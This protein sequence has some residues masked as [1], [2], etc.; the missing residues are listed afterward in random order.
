MKFKKPELKSAKKITTESLN[1]WNKRMALLHAV[2]GIAVLILSKAVAWPITTSYLTLDTLA[3]KGAGK[4]VLAS[5][6]RTLFNVNLGYFV[7][8]FFF[9]SAI[10]HAII[11]TKYRK[12]YEAD[13][14]KGVN[15]ARW[16]EYGVSA[17]TMMV[18]IALLSGINDL[19]SLIMIFVLDLI[20]NLMGLVMETHNQGAKKV[21]WLTYW[22]G[23]LAG[24]VPWIVFG[25]YV[26]GA[27]VNGSGIPT[28]VYFIYGS[29][30]IFF[31]SFAINMYLQYTKKGKWANYLYGERA[32]MILSLVAKTAL[33]WQVFIGTLRP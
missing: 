28:F 3:T 1:S 8:A 26:A 21:N 24:I 18:A 20:M 31:N 25:I 33:A 29:M 10:A 12:T 15:K 19:S 9:M 22:I 17:S 11:A 27:T 4:P 5:A 23:C 30:F 16:I 14:K 7:A 6:S 2:Q 13:L 32:Y